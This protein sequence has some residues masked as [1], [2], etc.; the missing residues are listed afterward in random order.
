[1]AAEQALFQTDID[2]E[3]SEEDFRLVVEL[4]RRE[5]GIVVRE[6]KQAMV[7]GRLVRR[8]RELGLPSIG[9]YCNR[10]KGPEL[11][12]ELPGLLNALTTNHTAFYREE[13]HFKHLEEVALPALIGSPPRNERLRIWCAAASTG[14]E[15]YTIA[16]TLAAYFGGRLHPDALILAT[17]LDTDVLSVAERGLYP[18]DT[19]AKLDEGKL[20]RLAISPAGDGRVAVGA[21]LKP[22]LRFRQLNI[23]HD[24]PFSGPFQAIFCRNMLIYFDQPT[25][26]RV[27][28]RLVT[29]LAPG[30]FLYLGHSEALPGVVR[31]LQLSGRTVYRRN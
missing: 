30:G 3:L 9:A 10:L 21:N 31:G 13:H 5:A 12:E 14:E 28:D 25:K 17:D 27:V 8:A 22:M 6:H 19:V 11:E 7:R 16:A 15:P 24:W 29:M 23:L 4:I 20:R 2:H 26:A 18:A 1:M